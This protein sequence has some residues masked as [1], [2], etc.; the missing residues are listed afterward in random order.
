MLG[1]LDGMFV[2]P[3]VCRWCARCVVS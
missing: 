2:F 1:I 3:N